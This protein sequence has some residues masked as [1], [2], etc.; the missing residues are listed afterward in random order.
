M[1]IFWKTVLFTFILLCSQNGMTQDAHRWLRQADKAYKKDK[2]DEAEES[3][4][5]AL[6]EDNSTQGT[7]NLG[8][9]TYRQEHFD[10]AIKYFE[11]AA[12]SATDDETRA[13]AFHNLGNAHFQKEEYD[14]SVQAYKN[15]LRLNPDDM[16]T[17]RNLVRALRRLPPPQPQN[18]PQQGEDE[19]QQSQPQPQEQPQDQQNQPQ[20]GEGD[21]EQEEP[22]QG[23]DQPRDLSREEA[24]KVA[25]DHGGA[26]AKSAGKTPQV[27][28]QKTQAGERLVDSMNNEKLIM[29]NGCRI[30]RRSIFFFCL[31]PFYFFLIQACTPDPDPNLNYADR[32]IVDS[33]FKK[34]VDSLLPVYDSLCE[35]QFDEAVQL[36]VD[37]MIAERKSEIEKYLERIRKEVGQ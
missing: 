12:T 23:P 10:E 7:Y 30:K 3:Y 1:K 13:K 6:E 26:G 36:K 11:S 32:K 17:K 21:E 24:E 37:S 2:F 9:S 29:Y 14:K 25:G 18:Q 28:E 27:A 33:L 34:T 22:Q 31:L 8:N 15:S 16:E 35:M 5:K 4:R 20:S 19:Q